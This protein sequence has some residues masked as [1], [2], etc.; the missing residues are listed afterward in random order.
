MLRIGIS[1]WQ[2]LHGGTV[3]AA[4]GA[5]GPSIAFSGSGI[6]PENTAVSTHLG[7][8][9]VSNG[10]GSYTFAFATGGNPSG[11]FSISTADLVLAGALDYETV[12]SY[13][14]VIEA[15]NGVDP[16]VSRPLTITVGDILDTAATLSSPTGVQTGFTTATGTVSTTQASGT[17]YAVVTTSA[18]PPSAAQVK[19]GQNNAGGAAAYASSHAATLGTNSF[20]ATGLT[21]A[22]TYY[23]YYM[24][25]N[26]AAIQS[27]VSASA[28]FTTATPDVT[29]PTLSNP[30]DTKTGQ[31][32]ATLT[33]D[34]NEANGTLYAVATTS[35]T[36]PS[37]A[38]VKLGQDNSGVAAAYAG[39]QAIG[40]TGTKNF[41]TT[42]LASG[43]AYTGFFM[44][45]DAAANQSTV[46]AANGFTTD[47]V[48]DT[49]A[50]TL[51]N[52]T[53]T[54]TGSTTATLTVD[55]NEAN[56]TLYA[57]A[58]T[59]GT[60]PSAAQVK[61]GQD[62]S[63]VAAAYAANQAIVSTGTKTF[64]A[65]GLTAATGYTAFFMHEDASS[66]Q[67]TV[68]AANGFTTDAGGGG[69][70]GEAIGLLLLLTKAA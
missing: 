19:A 27:T 53:D 49:T 26:A 60:P 21:G 67:S 9:S 44:H 24:Q 58:T 64:N 38:Q 25:E 10:A 48:P 56:G 63:G 23:F 50:P 14:L 43:T 42:G 28:A 30:T 68:S 22:T 12:A 5:D 2:G 1:L 51:T 39:N 16:V 33:V 41:S 7:T 20:S 34:T 57:V 15:T 17:L 66:N 70:A 31:T 11:K 35:A 46:S 13:V 29:A 54:K 32:T 55:T 36:P 40:S 47:A 37:A 18:T 8:F 6:V 62:N 52:P 45:E 61:L 69:A 4:V 59:S 3:G 65:T